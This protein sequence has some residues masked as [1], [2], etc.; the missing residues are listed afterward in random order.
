MFKKITF[1][2]LLVPIFIQA[3]IEP[4]KLGEEL[5]IA[6]QNTY[7]PVSTLGY[8][9]AR[10][11]LYSEIDNVGNDLFGIYSN[12]KV[13]LDPNE[14]PSISAYQ[15]G[16]GI[17]AEHVYPQS[18]GASSEPQK[19]DLHN[20]FPS[21]V[22]VNEARSSCEF[23]DIEDDDTDKW[24]FEATQSNSTPS[25]N[26]DAYSEKDDEDCGFEPRESVKGD[27][28]RAV[29]YF[30][31]IYQSAADGADPNFFHSQKEELYQWHLDDPVDAT[32][33][34]R[35]NGITDKQGNSNPFILDVT[36]VQRAYFPTSS[37]NNL[38]TVNW[39]SISSNLIEDELTIYSSKENGNVLLFNEIG[40][41]VRSS[42]LQQEITMN[43]AGLTS[44]IYILQ[45]QSGKSSKVFRIFKK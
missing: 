1:L 44:G 3:Q 35:N 18:K 28:A 40:Q 7:T 34:N 10:D 24:F 41:V 20:I 31:T 16:A 8:G 29:F 14:D 6:L 22:S 45:I 27:I 2:L 13:T 38:E 5:I 36:L 37:I 17:N 15:N 19:S 39:V 11:I 32:E 30:Y 4:G 33:E 26:I 43:L 23:R 12:F 25:S 21:K 42:G 9:P